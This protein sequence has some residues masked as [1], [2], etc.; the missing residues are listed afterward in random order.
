LISL[1]ALIICPS[2]HRKKLVERFYD[3]TDGKITLD[4][5]D[6]RTLNVKSLRS[7]IGLV[8]QEPK[9][10]AM[11]IFDNIAIG[12]PGATQEQVIEAAKQANAHDFIMS[13]SEGYD[14]DC[15]DEGAQLSGGQRQRIAIA[16][17]L[18]RKPKLILLDEA[19]SA[20][21]SESEAVVQVRFNR[22]PI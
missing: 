13:F 18:L 10:F 21:D 9:L 2:F 22:Y 12:C 3:V 11:S 14:T 16:R 8:S 6:I 1:V 5:R 20:L 4:G 7:Q 17:V 19:T 15:G